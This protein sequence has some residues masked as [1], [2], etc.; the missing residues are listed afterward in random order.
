MKE[1]NRSNHIILYIVFFISGAGALIYEVVWF[2]MLARIFG[3]T[4]YA[5]S[6]VLAVFMLGLAFGSFYF[7][8]LADRTR[9]PLLLYAFLQ[10]G[11]ALAGLL[12]PLAFQFATWAHVSLFHRIPG[13]SSVLPFIRIFICF[14][15]LLIPTTLMGGTFPLINRHVVRRLGHLGHR[16]SIL[17]GINTAGAVLGAGLSGFVLIA[18]WGEMNTTHLA[19]LL[20]ATAAVVALIVSLRVGEKIEVVKP[21]VTPQDISAQKRPRWLLPLLFITVFV[22]GLT[23]LSYEVLWTRTLT[24][25]LGTSIYAFS[26]ILVVFLAGIAIGSIIISRYIDVGENLLARLGLVIFSI[27]VAVLAIQHFFYR[28]GQ[29][30]FFVT[31]RWVGI[32]HWSDMGSFFL[33]SALV[34]LIVTLLFGMAFPLAV[35]IAVDNLDRFGQRLGSLYA[36]NT[37]GAVVG[38]LVAG[39]VMIPWLGTHSSV[40]AFALV[41]AALGVLLIA[42][43]RRLRI[44]R[45]AAAISVGSIA[46]VMLVI[47]A[48]DPF[49][50]TVSAEAARAGYDIVYHAEGADATVTILDKAALDDSRI[51]LV[52]GTPVSGVSVENVLMGHLPLMMHPHPEDVLVI[53]FGIGTAY[54][55]TLLYPVRAEA[56]EI[57]PN[58][59]EAFLKTD[60]LAAEIMDHPMGSI[61]IDDGRMF[62]LLTNNMYD[63][64]TV[65]ASPPLY[66]AGTVNLLTQEFILMAKR[67][68]NPGGQMMIWVPTT[69]ATVEDFRMILRTYASMFSHVSLWGLP[70]GSGVMMFGS[71]EPLVMDTGRVKSLIAQKSISDDLRVKA[72]DP[73]AVIKLLL[74]LFIIDDEDATRF[75]GEV[76]MITDDHPYT[77]FPLFRRTAGSKMMSNALLFSLKDQDHV[78]RLATGSNH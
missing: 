67:R 18:L 49:L 72:D 47:A 32:K 21:N 62:L 11:I 8:R 53:C 4:V 2:R 70:Y 20:N 69:S 74:W 78:S 37:M 6:T 63:V 51:L 5:T 19:V 66:S 16:M 73:D 52:N 9:R 31:L 15:C 26:T 58:V 54:K 22:C 30:P 61:R 60:P 25:F 24:V 65:D 56:V 39:F 50:G 77:E 13:P 1:S 57:S 36:V 14:A 28:L 43:A 76:P 68:L 59:I 29:M 33:S 3:N 44:F 41:N 55:S 38:S 34:I 7:G 45:W 35:K 27:G 48:K 17:Y 10:G 64:I 75:A 42:V 23:A 12:M 71:D 40:I 46:I